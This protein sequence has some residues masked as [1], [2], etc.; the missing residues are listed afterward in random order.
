MA[1]SI[2]D[3]TSLADRLSG[4][5]IHHTISITSSKGIMFSVA[6]PGE[7]WEIELMEDGTTEVEIFR[8]NGD[9]TDASK[10]DE[11]FDRFAQ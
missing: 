9:I 1:G 3:V 11:L 6:V 4:A 5:E 7:R 8:S 2:T 10:V